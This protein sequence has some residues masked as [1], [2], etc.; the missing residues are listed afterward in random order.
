MIWAQNNKNIVLRQ[1]GTGVSAFNEIAEKARRPGLHFQ[2][3][4]LTGCGRRGS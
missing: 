3:T 4:A 1:C 2:M